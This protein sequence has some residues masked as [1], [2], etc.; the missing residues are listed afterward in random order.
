VARQA[1]KSSEEKKR[2]SIGGRRH[3]E[4][5]LSAHTQNRSHSPLLRP[6]QLGSRHRALWTTADLAQY[7]MSQKGHFEE[8]FSVFVCFL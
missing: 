6:S 3:S 5:S 1:I 7:G 2:S 4:Q 8:I